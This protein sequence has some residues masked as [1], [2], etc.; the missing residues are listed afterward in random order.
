MTAFVL[1]C[2]HTKVRNRRILPVSARPGEGHLAEPIADVQPARRELVFMPP[3]RTLAH[4]SAKRLSLNAII[5][6]A[7]SGR[8]FACLASARLFAV[9]QVQRESMDSPRRYQEE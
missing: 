9:A 8:A 4:T 7:V 5:C 1:P 3:F 2:G 6:S